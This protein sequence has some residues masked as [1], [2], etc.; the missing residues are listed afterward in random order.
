[1]RFA[2][3]LTPL[4]CWG[5]YVVERMREYTSLFSTRIDVGGF[6]VQGPKVLVHS[7][8]SCL[9]LLTLTAYCQVCGIWCHAG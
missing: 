3:V 8:V 5:S 4:L 9:I 1:M 2:L 7:Y 6:V